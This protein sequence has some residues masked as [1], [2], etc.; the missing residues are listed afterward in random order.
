MAYRDLC[1]YV[2]EQGESSQVDPYPS[3]AK[4]LLHILWQCT[5]LEMKISKLCQVQLVSI[6]TIERRVVVANLPISSSAY[7]SKET[8]H[9]TLHNYRIKSLTPEAI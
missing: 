1:E 9:C 2:E 8:K 6:E 4:S 3:P 7:C 5:H